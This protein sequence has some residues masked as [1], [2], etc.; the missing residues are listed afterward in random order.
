[1]PLLPEQ[2]TALDSLLLGLAPGQNP[3]PTIRSE[4]PSL[5]V[6]RCSADDMR[7]ETPFRSVGSF[8]LYLLASADHCLHLT[9]DAECANGVVIAARG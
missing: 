8:H 3:V 5:Q 9:N 6:L 7:D 2:L 4:M 1:M